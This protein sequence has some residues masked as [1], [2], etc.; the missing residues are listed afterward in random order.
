MMLWRRARLNVLNHT[1]QLHTSIS[2]TEYTDFSHTTDHHPRPTT[3][4]SPHLIQ[5]FV[6][7][8]VLVAEHQPGAR[9]LRPFPDRWQLAL[10][11]TPVWGGCGGGRAPQDGAWRTAHKCNKTPGQSPGS[12]CLVS[13]AVP[14]TAEQRARN[15]QPQI[16]LAAVAAD[17]ASTHLWHGSPRKQTWCGCRLPAPARRAAGAAP[18]HRCPPAPARQLRTP[19]RWLQVVGGRQEGA[20]Q[21]GG[22]ARQEA[23]DLR[24]TASAWQALVPVGTSSRN[25]SGGSYECW[26]SLVHAWKDAGPSPSAH[27]CRGPARQA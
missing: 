3:H 15:G 1:H 19:P 4:C 13:A 8:C 21:L 17:Q 2:T 22:A 26:A 14:A 11:R 10:R 6:D 24:Q 9:V 16:D 18:T 5:H 12:T 23:A 27:Q 25:V 20:E 7:V